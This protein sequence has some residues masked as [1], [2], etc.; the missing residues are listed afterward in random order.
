MGRNSCKTALAMLTAIWLLKRRIKVAVHIF[1][2]GCKINLFISKKPKL[3]YFIL[4]GGHTLFIFYD[5]CR[6]YLL[7]KAFLKVCRAI[8][9]SFFFITNVSLKAWFFFSNTTPKLRPTNKGFVFYRIIK[10][11]CLSKC[12][13]L[14]L[15][16]I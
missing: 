10:Q 2:E 4:N 14:E 13:H 16:I 3:V 1:A 7:E 8:L 9:T 5:N 6:C 15:Y 12:L 11:T